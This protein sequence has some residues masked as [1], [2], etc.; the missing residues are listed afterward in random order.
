MNQQNEITN[1][2]K[3]SYIQTNWDEYV[4]NVFNN[5]DAMSLEEMWEVVL[6]AEEYQEA[7][8]LE[9]EEELERQAQERNR[10]FQEQL[11][12][13]RRLFALGLYELE[14]GEILE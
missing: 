3:N 7:M 11:A 5:L 8:D 9:E 6:D 13:R 10:Q 1:S 2:N 4:T 12:E 14:E